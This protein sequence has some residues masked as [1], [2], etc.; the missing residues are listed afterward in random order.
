[1]TGLNPGALL[2]QQVTGVFV[3]APLPTA[4]CI[5]EVDFNAGALSEDFLAV[6]L[7]ALVVGCGL[8]HCCRLALAPQVEAHG[9]DNGA[10]VIV[11][12]L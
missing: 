10:L 2:A 4:V 12:C 7:A 5:S 3:E 11:G 1:M 8:A 6:Q 9:R